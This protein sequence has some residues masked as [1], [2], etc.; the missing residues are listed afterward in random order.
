MGE[1]LRV[2][3]SNGLP[4]V[5]IT[6]LPIHYKVVLRHDVRI[7]QVGSSI[8]SSAPESFSLYNKGS[9][10]S[11]IIGVFSSTFT[12]RIRFFEVTKRYILW[13]LSKAESWLTDHLIAPIDCWNAAHDSISEDAR[14]KDS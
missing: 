14:Y 2:K 11:M 10:D 13:R 8:D 7:P 12:S 3:K 4:N 6:G 9:D 5:V 1:L